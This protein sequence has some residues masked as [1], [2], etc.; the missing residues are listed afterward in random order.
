MA[1]EYKR[2]RYPG[3]TPQGDGTYR[4]RCVVRH[5]KT[6]R[7]HEIDRVVKAKDAAAASRRRERLRDDWLAR[8]GRAARKRGPERL[9]AAMSAWLAEKAATVK[10]STASTYG[11]AVAWWTAVLGDYYLAE[12]EPRD[13]REAL[14]GSREGGD[15]SATR[16]GRLRVLRTFAREWRCEGI[17]D[18]VSVKRDVREEERLEDEGRG[19]S[20]A[21]LRRFLDAGP[22]AH[23]TK[24]GAV[25][26]PWPR[27]W[28]L[29]ATMAWTG[30]RF[31]EASALEWHDIDLDAC[32]IR[33]RRG[34]W[35]GHVGHV[36]AKA[37]KR[38][39]VIPG[40]LADL[41]REHRR[42]MF[43]KQLPG[44]GS[45]LVFPSRRGG[46]HVTNTY[47][48]KA[49]LKV[50]QAARI[51]LGGR[52]ALHC[53]RHTANNLVRQNADELVR[54]ALVGHADAAIG[55]RYSAV[56]M[57]E[58]RAAVGGVVRMVRGSE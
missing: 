29:I 47:A 35:R 50:Y 54:Q 34:Q 19:L 46:G 17:V 57:D 23:R 5:P 39:V 14:A 13:V 24:A 55:E 42:A 48:R 20:L 25:Y 6:G 7:Q 51:S 2:K 15:T 58:R 21:E 56:T 43:A 28:A 41:L 45:P 1:R 26:K 31:S 49:A 40:E 30:L 11:G 3:V 36:K 33:V 8:H 10:P 18:R 16:D 12:I 52:P 37:S 9:G 27:A 32:T 4:V 53:L 22:T 38:T 44:V